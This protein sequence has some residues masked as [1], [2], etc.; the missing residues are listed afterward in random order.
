MTD[1]PTTTLYLTPRYSTDSQKLW[2]A[3]SARG[4]HV[5]R[6]TGWKLPEHEAIAARSLLY[7]EALM[8]PMLAEVLGVELAR[9]SADWLPR[10]PEEYL[11]RRVRMCT[12]GEARQSTEPVFVKPPNDKSFPACVYAPGELSVAYDDDEAVIVA[13]PVHWDLEFRCFALDRRILT[14]SL[15]A[16]DG[17]LCDEEEPPLVSSAEADAMLLLA[18]AVLADERVALPRAIVLDVGHIRSRGWGVVEA[19]AAWGA[20]I[21]NCDPDAVLDVLMHACLPTSVK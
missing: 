19:N 2:R 14:W 16:V 15:Y 11:L 3:A 18:A 21:Y 8:A 9:P 17:E 12:L 10:L 20:G 5:A 4:W 1:N 7:V 6:L 13:E